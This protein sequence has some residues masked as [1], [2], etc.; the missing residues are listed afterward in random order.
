MK[1][2]VGTFID[3]SKELR[4]WTN[5]GLKAITIGIVMYHTIP[6]FKHFV[7][8]KIEDFKY[9]DVEFKEVK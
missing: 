2:N 7:D 3:I 4:L 1:I 9:K 5:N 8:E 6:G